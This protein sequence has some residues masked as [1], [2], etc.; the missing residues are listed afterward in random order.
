MVWLLK[1]CEM[2]MTDSG[3]LQKEAF[4]FGKPCVTLRDETEW[5]E[6][7]ENGFNKVVGSDYQTILTGFQLMQKVNMDFR[8]NLYG[9]GTASKKIVRELLIF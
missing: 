5:A 2:V 9:N 4:F 1:N 3:G 7:V 8:K 6:L